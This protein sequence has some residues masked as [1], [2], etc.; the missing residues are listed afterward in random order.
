MQ[1]S[2]G[3]VAF[4][5]RFLIAFDDLVCDGVVARLFLAKEHNKT[6]D[7]YDDGTDY[8]MIAATI[9]GFFQSIWPMAIP[10]RV[11]RVVSVAFTRRGFYPHSRHSPIDT[12]PGIANPRMW[13]GE[14]SGAGGRGTGSTARRAVAH[15]ERG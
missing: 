3:R 11:R 5:D 2:N 7:G 1:G 6:D 14:G 4:A 8:A 15:R 10:F 12:V 9:V 13:R